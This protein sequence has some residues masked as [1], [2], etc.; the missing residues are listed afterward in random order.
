MPPIVATAPINWC[1]DLDPSGLEPPSYPDLLDRMRDAGFAATEW[2]DALPRFVPTLRRDLAARGLD[3][4]GAYL[5][6][7]LHDHAWHVPAVAAAAEAATFLARIGGRYLVLG[8]AGDARRDA[9]AGRAAPAD[10]L[11]PPAFAALA[12]G[13]RRIGEAVGALG[14]RAVVHPH[15]GT[16]VET[17]D[18]VRRLADALDPAAAGFCL[19]TGHAAY[20]GADPRALLDELGPRVEYVHLK[21][22]DGDVLARVVGDERSFRDALRAVVFCPLGA[23]TVDVRGILGDL[24]ARAYDGVLVVEQDTSWDPH[25]SA[26]ANRAFVEEV[27]GW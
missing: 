2:S 25:G 22:V 18:E 6:V 12:E 10:A 20:G 7:R 4:V 23:G 17:L 8:E 15:V 5:P 24:A 16:Y 1:N 19:D 26:R 9:R 27:V 13:I 11:P 3:V 14:V 21:D